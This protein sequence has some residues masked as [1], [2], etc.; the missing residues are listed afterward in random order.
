[1]LAVSGGTHSVC[2]CT[3]HQNPKLQLA[4]LGERGLSYIDLLDYSVCSSEKETCMMQLCNDYPGEE[5][6]LNFLELLDKVKSAPTEVTY[7]QW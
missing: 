7:K 2:V 4:A 1:M 5:G 3:W 6:V